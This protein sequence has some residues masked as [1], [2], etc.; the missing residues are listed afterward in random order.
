MRTGISNSSGIS[1][2]PSV[3]SHSMQ[4]H[5]QT[6]SLFQHKTVSDA[7]MSNKKMPD[8]CLIFVLFLHDQYSRICS[9]KQPGCGPLLIEG[10]D[11][12]FQDTWIFAEHHRDKVLVVD[13]A[14]VGGVHLCDHFFQLQVSLRLPQLLHHVLHIHDV[15]Q[16]HTH[17]AITILSICESVCECLC[18]SACTLCPRCLT[19]IHTCHHYLSLCESAVCLSLSVCVLQHVLYVHDV[20]PTQCVTM[21]FLSTCDE[22]ACIH[23]H[24]HAHTH[25]HMYT[26]THM[27]ACMHARAHT[28]THTLACM[29]THSH[30][31]ARKNIHTEHSMPTCP[32]Y[33]H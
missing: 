31:H 13:G 5:C 30:V 28:H 7:F 33:T 1:K 9:T 4:R 14:G 29:N 27:Y 32:I 6:H 16:I 8:F 20:W 24:T 19:S 23:T 3:V 25:K 15:W 17:I 10:A 18:F 21:T 2:I 22:H 12:L 11:S 26:H